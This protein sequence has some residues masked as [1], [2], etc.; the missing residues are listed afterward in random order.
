VPGAIR[1]K[2]NSAS[3]NVVIGVALLFAL[4]PICFA[5][6]MLD[7][8]EYLYALTG[9]AAFVG[10]LAPAGM[11]ARTLGADIEVDDEGIR[12]IDSKGRVV[13]IRWSEPHELEHETVVVQRMGVP[14]SRVTKMKV[15]AAGR[16]IRFSATYGGA[17]GA[18]ARLAK[19]A[20]LTSAGPGVERAIALSAAARA[21]A[22]AR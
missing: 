10:I 6:G 18:A 7:R 5:F 2:V 11:L 12:R 16:T 14:M 21:R 15:T 22:P 3:S 19:N 8:G 20:D 9:L 17:T 13:S 4:A 1:F